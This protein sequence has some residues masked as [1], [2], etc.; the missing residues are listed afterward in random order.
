VPGRPGRPALLPP[1]AEPKWGVFHLI[2]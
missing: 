2:A 1:P